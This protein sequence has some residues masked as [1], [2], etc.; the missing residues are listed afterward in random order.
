MDVM[1]NIKK[2]LICTL[3]SKVYVAHFFNKNIDS[4]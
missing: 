3:M 4:H 1:T 2:P